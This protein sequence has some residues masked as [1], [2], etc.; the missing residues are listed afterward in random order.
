MPAPANDLFSAPIQQQPYE[1][2]RMAWGKATAATSAAIPAQ[3]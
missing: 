1:I 2:N 3:K